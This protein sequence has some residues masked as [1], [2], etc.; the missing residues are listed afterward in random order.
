MILLRWSKSGLALLSYEI[1]NMFAFRIEPASEPT[2]KVD[3][4]SIDWENEVPTQESKVDE[5]QD[6][7]NIENHTLFLA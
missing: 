5:L 2:M 6:T 4:S 1:G 7:A 3:L